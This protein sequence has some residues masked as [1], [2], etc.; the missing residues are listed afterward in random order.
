MR[1][2]IL[3]IGPWK[4]APSVGEKNVRYIYPSL[5]EPLNGCKFHLLHGKPELPDYTIELTDKYGLRY[6]KVKSR[7]EKYWIR[8]AADIVKKHKIDIVTNVF[9]GYRFGYIAA[10]VAKL[11]GCRSVVRFAGNEIYTKKCSGVYKGVRG[12]LNFIKEK[13]RELMAA[14]L[15]D[16]I[17][18]MSPWEKERVSKIAA[19]NKINWC[20]RGIDT[21]RFS[22]NG[23]SNRDK[24]RKF[25]FIG[26]KVKEKGY[27]LIE[28]VAKD[29]EL[30]HPDANF[31]FA[32]TFAPKVEGN[33][34]YLGYY[35]TDQLI[36]LYSDMD[37]LI[38]PSESEGFAN[39][40][41]EAMSMGLPCIISKH[42]HR[43][44]FEDGQNALLTELTTEDLKTQILRIYNNSDLAG[45]LGS[46]S[47]TLAEKDFDS[48]KWS[49]IYRKI[50]LNETT[51]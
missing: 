16:A 33:R 14:R 2:K 36:D 47:R 13:H 44:Y 48:K 21:E 34:E 11:T 37:C 17:I 24:A 10:K 9:F 38:L 3:Y 29:L 1:N 42:L 7:S 26:R 51:E 28:N 18:V 50:I 39:V 8:T 20:M 45:K 15:A 31:F 22:K 25:L 5:F 12:R 23:R 4:F 19:S 32:G 46:N 43:D 49:K 6:H 40:I 30:S 41:V 35:S 27:P